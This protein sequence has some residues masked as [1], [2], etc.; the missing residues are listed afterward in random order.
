MQFKTILVALTAVTVAS[1]A[2]SS[3]GS[4]GSNDSSTS[5]DSGANQVVGAGLIGAAA[6]AGVALM[7]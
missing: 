5:A 3:N 6:A 7:L 2:N 1:A 4:N